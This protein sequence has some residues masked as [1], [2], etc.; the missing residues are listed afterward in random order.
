MN[1]AK[2]CIVKPGSKVKLAKID[3]NSTP[4]FRDKTEGEEALLASSARLEELEYLLYASRQNALLVVLQGM[5]TAGKD[6]AIRHVASALNPQSSDVTAFKKPTEEEMAHDFLWRIHKAVPPKGVI[7]IFNRSQYEDVLVVRVH[8]LVPKAVWSKRYEQI[9]N[10][11]QMLSEGGVTILKFFLHISKD[12][13]KKRLEQRLAD[14]AKNWKSTPNDFT[15]RKYWDDYAAAYEEVLSRCSTPW[16]PW[17]IVP[18]N[19][20][21][22]RN[23]VISQ[24]IVETLEGLDMKLPKSAMD[25]TPITVE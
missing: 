9:N 6:G 24:T 13:Q 20:K 23:A 4:G 21:W 11:E 22:Y 15:E 18:A 1:L 14:P 17:F 19:R 5:D 10:F 8:E 2:K 12:E 3:P 16:A 7:G 25:V